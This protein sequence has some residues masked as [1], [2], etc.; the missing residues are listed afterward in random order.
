MGAINT[1]QGTVSPLLAPIPSQAT[2]KITLSHETHRW[3]NTL[4]Q[5]FLPMQAERANEGNLDATGT[6]S[7]E[8]TIKF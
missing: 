7:G 4:L 5:A 2:S 1:S 6:Q 8:R 3:K